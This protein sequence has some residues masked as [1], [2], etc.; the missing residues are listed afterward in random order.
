MRFGVLFVVQLVFLFGQVSFWARDSLL[1]EG[2]YAEALAFYDSLLRGGVLGDTLRLRVYLKGA[3]AWAGVNRPKEALLWIEPAESLAL[4]LGDS[5]SYAEIVG[6]KAAYF[7]QS[8]AYIEAKEALQRATHLLE[9]K[10]LEKSLLYASLQRRWGVVAQNQGEYQKAISHYLRAKSLLEELGLTKHGA[11]GIILRSLGGVYLALKRLTEA[12]SLYLQAKALLFQ[13]YGIH[14]PEYL[15]SLHDLANLYAA[16][17]RYAE[18]EALYLQAKEGRA[19]ALGLY[20]P[21]YA[22]TLHSLANVYYLQGRYKEAESL[23]RQASEI[24]ARSLGTFHPEY[25][26]ILNNLASV[27]LA[28]GQYA[29]AETLYLQVR[30]IQAK[31]LGL[32]HLEYARTLYNLANLYNTQGRYVEA[33]ALHLQSREIRAKILGSHHLEYAQSLLGLGGVYLNEGRYAEAENLYLEAKGI[34]AK[35]LGLHHPDYAVTLNKLATLYTTQGRYS[36]AE[37]LYLEAKG[38]WA[39]AFGEGHPDYGRIL[40]NLATLY[41]ATGQHAKAESLYLHLRQLQIQSLG[42]RHPEHARVLSNLGHLYYE[43][44]RYAEAESLYLQAK[45]IWQQAFSSEHPEYYSHFLYNIAR[46]YWRQGRYAEADTVW[47]HI[48]QG[49]FLQIR[50]AFPTLPLSARRDFLENRVKGPLLEFQQYVAERSITNPAI[51]ELGYRA[52]RSFKGLLLSSTEAM[53]QLIEASND[54][55]LQALYRQWKALADQYA[56]FSFQETYTAT[57]SIWKELQAIERQIVL[58]LPTLK[59]YLPDPAQEPLFPPLKAQEALVEVIRVPVGKSD[60]VLYLFYLIVQKGWRPTLRLYTYRVDG[61]W[62]HKVQNAYE[63]F[64]SPVA[65]LSGAPYLLCWRFIDSLLPPRVRVVYLSPDGVYYRINAAS[66]YDA[67]HGR[68][69]ID[70]YQV[71]YLASSRRLFFSPM[72]LVQQKPVVIGNPDFAAAPDTVQGQGLRAYRLFAQ[73]IP[74]LPGAEKEAREIAQLLGITPVIGKAATERFVKELRSPRILHIATHGYFVAEKKNPLLAGGVLFA[75]AAVWDSLFP[76]LGEEDGCLTTQEAANLNLLGTELVVLSACET[77]L[78]EVMGDG[79]Y[80]LQRAFLEAGAKRVVATLWQ[81]DD[82]ATRELMLSFYQRLRRV[83][84][85]EKIDTAFAEALREFRRRHPQ[86]YYWG[87]FIV[88]R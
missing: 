54:S 71:R 72:S 45:D 12:E 38:I 3:E 35:A 17:G 19:K 55:S 24:Q 65:P 63:V 43:Q 83:K 5:L 31:V 40:N 1:E 87:A 84:E 7:S 20:H 34:R 30:E 49:I 79:L 62:E 10:G 56:F 47:Q 48:V 64:H 69:V 23:Y 27:H 88:M 53:K 86:P 66:L 80:G 58:R 77:A 82:E 32:Q 33:E 41:T 28:Q 57:D 2:K 81:V 76:P 46:L 9:A 26:R 61:A 42:S 22:R 68:F 18:A 74:P 39:R 8:G 73:G 67:E 13:L 51:I 21:D 78:G 11:Y 50:R 36:E 15:R 75:R 29:E 70:R 52:A 37:A 85:K 25:A 44:K 59:N 60:S 4:R 6:W 16:Q 14:H